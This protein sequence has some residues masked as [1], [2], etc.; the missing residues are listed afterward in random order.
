VEADLRGGAL[1][2]KTDNVKEIAINLD[3]VSRLITFSKYDVNAKETIRLAIV[4][5]GKTLFET[6]ASGRKSGQ[7]P[8]TLFKK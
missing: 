7:L 1:K 6:T 4:K 2:V 8:E 3:Q 5:G